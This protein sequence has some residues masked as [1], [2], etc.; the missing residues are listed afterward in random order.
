MAVWLLLHRDDGFVPSRVE[1]LHVVVLQFDHPPLTMEGKSYINHAT[2]LPVRK[3]YLLVPVKISLRPLAMF[4]SRTSKLICNVALV[5][6][7]DVFSSATDFADSIS[8]IQVPA[9]IGRLAPEDTSEIHLPNPQFSDFQQGFEVKFFHFLFLVFLASR[10][11][12]PGQAVLKAKCGLQASGHPVLQTNSA[13]LLQ[14]RKAL[15]SIIVRPA[16][17]L[18]KLQVLSSTAKNVCLKSVGLEN[19]HSA[20]QRG[21]NT[22]KSARER[23]RINHKIVRSWMWVSV[24]LR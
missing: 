16:Q 2:C 17:I 1:R 5:I 12:S 21:V 15:S 6:V 24:E 13:L 20:R 10:S 19:G 18:R 7:F 23:E 3:C 8:L 11:G 4:D 22:Q 14:M 9:S